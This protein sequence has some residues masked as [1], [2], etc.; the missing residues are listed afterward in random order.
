MKKAFEKIKQD[1]RHAQILVL[2]S[3]AVDERGFSGRPMAFIDATG[4][5]EDG[6]GI[7]EFERVAAIRARVDAQD[8]AARDLMSF[9]A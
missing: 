5:E 4:M 9:A 7:A 1:P 6:L 3:R 8:R 2:E